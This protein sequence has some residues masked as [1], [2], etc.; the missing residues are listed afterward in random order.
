M[1]RNIGETNLRV[2]RSSLDPMRSYDAL[3]KQL[4]QWLAQAALPWSPASARKIWNRAQSQGC[5]L[6]DTL[7]LLGRA[8]RITLARDQ[9]RALRNQTVRG[10][11][12]KD[13]E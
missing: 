6:D 10:L 1:N 2:R 8:E 3:P 11:L 5:S 9:R 12:D 4:R 7:V 13:A